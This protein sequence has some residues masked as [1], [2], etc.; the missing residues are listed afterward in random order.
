MSRPS[1]QH[2]LN[3]LIRKKNEHKANRQI[4][5]TD[6]G[7][8]TYQV[9]NQTPNEIIIVNT[10][11][12]PLKES[13]DGLIASR[14]NLLLASLGKQAELVS[15]VV[16]A[17]NRL[18][19]TKICVECILKYTADIEYELILVDNGSTDQTLNY[20]IS[21]EHPRKKIIRVTNNIGSSV[22]I[23][24]R[25]L[26]GRYFAYI[27]NDVYVTQNWLTNL[28]AC[29]KSEDAIGM[30]APVF[31]NATDLQGADIIFSSLEE[32]QEKAAAHNISNPA[33]WHDRLTLTPV[34][35]LY[36]REALE[37]VG[38]LDYGYF[39]DF[40]DYDLTYRIR[41][42]GYK[43][44]LCRDTFVDHDHIRT[45]SDKKDIEQYRR[46][47]ETGKTDFKN[48][49]FGIDAWDDVYNYEVVMMSLVNPHNHQGSQKVE[50]LGIDVLCGT[51]LLE[52]KNKLREAH[53][54]DARLSAFSTDPKYWLDLNTI[55]TG[56]VVVDRI[57]FMNEHFV[58]TCFDY[59]ILG[60]PIN[61]YQNPLELLH[62]LLKHLKS[63][64]HLLLKLRNT[65][66]VVSLFKTLGA[67]IPA[68]VNNGYQLSV[69]ELIGHEK[70]AGFIHKKIAFENWPLSEQDQIILRNT[71][72]ATSFNKNPDE[73]FFRA[74][75]R[76]YVF[77]IIRN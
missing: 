62:S 20:F 17:Y 3:N 74:V 35:G 39:H 34:V 16:Q 71:I 73:T 21:V 53:V 59:V 30:V 10:D 51:P 68:S 50:I 5:L 18:E 72:T 4:D 58:G 9:T 29:L 60:K 77:D 46:S 28:L 42:A 55:C 75:V 45:Q 25:Q 2:N 36:K 27:T 1:R 6:I 26:S 23:V 15:I 8:A 7:L 67:G 24:F 66:D 37:I 33:L 56:D 32:M 19:K 64:G 47:L 57:E 44:V 76:D 41:R 38:M 43:T 31:S 49:F 65:Y 13:D 11:D 70:N 48:K 14:K 69:E 63:D 22:P 52:L 40:G 54:Y 61:A 12:P